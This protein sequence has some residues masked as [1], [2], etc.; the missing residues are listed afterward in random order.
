VNNESQESLTAKKIGLPN[1]RVMMN[2]IIEILNESKT[3]VSSSEM[4][5]RIIDIFELDDSQI[6]TVISSGTTTILRKEIAWARQ[7]A[8][9]K[10]YIKYVRSEKLWVSTY[11]K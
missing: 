4:F 7:M 2:S 6:Q 9:D 8:A 5:E 10:G 11:K 3:G 1:R